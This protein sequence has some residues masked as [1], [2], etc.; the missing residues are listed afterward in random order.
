[1]NNL[2]V[3]LGRQGKHDE[4]EAIHQQE[5]GLIERVLGPEHPETLTSVGNLAVVLDRQGKY[6]AAEKMYRRALEQYSTVL[7]PEHPGRLTSMSNLAVVLDSRGKYDEACLDY[8]LHGQEQYGD[9]SIL[10]QRAS[11]GY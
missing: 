9:A 11:L 5:L 8:L 2:A 6:D 1:M 4:A 3:A 10:Y 7:G